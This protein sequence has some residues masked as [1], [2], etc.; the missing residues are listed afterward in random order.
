[1]VDGTVLGTTIVSLMVN[2]LC[3]AFQQK[4]EREH[5]EAMRRDLR[6]EYWQ[7]RLMDL[8]IEHRSRGGGGSSS[9][10][11]SRGEQ[12]D[13]A[14]AGSYSASDSSTR[15]ASRQER[16]P[17]ALV[18]TTPT[19]SASSSPQ[20]TPTRRSRAMLIM[21]NLGSEGGGGGGGVQGPPHPANPILKT[22]SL[23]DDGA[24]DSDES[25]GDDARCRNNSL[26]DASEEY[27]HEVK[28]MDEEGF[29]D[30]S[31]I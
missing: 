29:T 1:M 4:E 25:Q 10:S 12:R 23:M 30:I 17:P 14:S 31:L 16:R 9:S 28:G 3:C 18:T 21:G 22:A 20:T 15:T 19:S 8:E 7:Q 6:T 27:S 24:D 5:R 11:N 13:E 2:G 26:F